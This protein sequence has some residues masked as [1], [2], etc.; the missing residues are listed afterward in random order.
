MHR[1]GTHTMVARP[2][3]LPAQMRHKIQMWVAVYPTLPAEDA[4]SKEPEAKEVC[5]RNLP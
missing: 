3:Q 4:R 2:S 1:L 5:K